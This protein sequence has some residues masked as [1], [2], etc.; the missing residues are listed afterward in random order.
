MND[1]AAASS[2]GW[3]DLDAAASERVGTLL[4]SLK[5]PATLDVLGL[6]VVRDAF[7]DMLSPGTSTVQTRLRYFLFLPWI[8]QHLEAQRISPSDFA[9]RLRQSETKLI[10]CLRNLG[11]NHGVIGYTARQDLKR[12]PS[13]IYWGGLGAWGI[14]QLDLSLA[15]YAP[16]AAAIGRLQPD[17]DND[18]NATERAVSMW[19]P[20]PRVQ[21]LA[22]ALQSARFALP[23]GVDDLRIHI[24]GLPSTHSPL[25]LAAK[26]SLVFDRGPAKIDRH[27]PVLPFSRD[28]AA[29]LKL[30]K[31]L[32]A[33]R[34]AFGQPRRR[35]TGRVPRS[36]PLRRRIGEAPHRLVAPLSRVP[37]APATGA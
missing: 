1:Y 37:L 33:Y 13:E 17:R 19:A 18:G 11:P 7:S 8:C 34:L 10:D 15:E 6:G 24:L 3:L 31:T 25:P 16:R 2:L 35:R 23:D 22:A 4:R 28:A 30:R 26:R 12:M 29:L 9:R 36:Q 14:R 32:A 27:V 5:E 21:S 20:S